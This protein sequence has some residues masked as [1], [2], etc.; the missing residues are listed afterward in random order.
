MSTAKNNPIIVV[1]DVPGMT[2]EQYD[3]VIK[4]LEAAGAGSPRGRLYH[5]ASAKTDGWLVVDVWESAERL[6]QFAQTLMPSLQK[7]GV[8][9]PQPQIYPT[10][11]IIKG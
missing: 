3:Q 2:P 4:D 5:V 11:N 7:V 10:H 1:F 8:T 6:D 9:P